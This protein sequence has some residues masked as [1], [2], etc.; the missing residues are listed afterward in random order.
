MRRVQAVAFAAIATLAPPAL[1]ADKTPELPPAE[2]EI[3]AVERGFFVENDI[4]L[5]IVVNKLGNTSFAP[6]PVI[7][8]TAGYDF[9]PIFSAAIGVLGI[10]VSATLTTPAEDDLEPS[11]D[12]FYI[13]PMASL[14]LAL[15]ST[16]RNFVFVRGGAGFALGL[17][18]KSNGVDAGG[19]GPIFSVV[20]G[21]ERYTKLR[22]FSIGVTAGVLILTKPDVGVGIQISPMLKYTF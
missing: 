9:N 2:Q 4:G 14:Q 12:V 10:P 3:R 8:I 18:E 11:A 7:G 5:A 20:G 17:P 6:S 15:L 13:A 16:E 1:A 22:H 19:N 21:Y